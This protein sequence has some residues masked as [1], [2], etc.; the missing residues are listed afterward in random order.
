MIHRGA[1]PP[2]GLSTTSSRAPV[3]QLGQKRYPRC[4]ASLAQ[5]RAFTQAR[6][7]TAPWLQPAA[8]SCGLDLHAA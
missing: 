7:L 8:L 5:G 2:S 1:S 3:R 6:F 4:T